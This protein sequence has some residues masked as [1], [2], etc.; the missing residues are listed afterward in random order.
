MSE[1]KYWVIKAFVPLSE[2]EKYDGVLHSK[3]Q[4]RGRFTMQLAGY[5]KVP[6]NL[7][8][9]IVSKVKG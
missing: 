6:A 3:T 5:S 2:M 1:N 9:E 4:G 8:K 7:E